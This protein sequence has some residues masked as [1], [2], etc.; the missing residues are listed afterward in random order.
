MSGKSCYWGG[1]QDRARKGLETSKYLINLTLLS[2]T[3]NLGWGNAVTGTG[4]E[5]NI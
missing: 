3:H 4:N 5:R 1:K 2:K